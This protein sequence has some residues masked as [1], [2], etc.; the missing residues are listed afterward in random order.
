MLAGMH[1]GPQLG[2]HAPPD[3]GI[4]KNGGDM[5]EVG[6]RIQSRRT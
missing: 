1:R 5:D 6:R 2:T 3:N 4:A